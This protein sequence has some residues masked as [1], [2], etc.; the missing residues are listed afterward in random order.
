MRVIDP[1]ILSKYS[2]VILFA[3]ASGQTPS[4]VVTEAPE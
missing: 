3:V 4:S 2:D 1:L